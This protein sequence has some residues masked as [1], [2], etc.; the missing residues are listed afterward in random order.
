M[1]TLSPENKRKI[2]VRKKR[3]ILIRIEGKF[4]QEI[5]EDYID[6]C[7]RCHL[8]LYEQRFAAEYWKIFV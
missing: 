1:Q 2:S 4:S 7:V 5:T 6:D 3:F 8:D